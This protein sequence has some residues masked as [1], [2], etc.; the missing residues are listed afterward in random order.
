MTKIETKAET[1]AKTKVETKAET[2]TETKKYGCLNSP[3][4]CP[5]F[6]A[7]MDVPLSKLPKLPKL[8]K[9][10]YKAK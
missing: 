7:L 2:K 9:T 1:K 4:T 10:I 3:C 6:H 5:E 8:P